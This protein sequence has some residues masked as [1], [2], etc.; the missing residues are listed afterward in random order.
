MQE[1]QLPLGD[2]ASYGLRPVA[3]IELPGM[4]DNPDSQDETMFVGLS[5]CQV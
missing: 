2:W 5:P 3:G 1:L 4:P